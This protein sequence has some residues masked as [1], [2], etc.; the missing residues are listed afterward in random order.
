MWPEMAM[1]LIKVTASPLIAGRKNF[2]AAFLVFQQ[3]FSL[4]IGAR[5]LA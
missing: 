1:P 3:H 2:L 4:P 5:R